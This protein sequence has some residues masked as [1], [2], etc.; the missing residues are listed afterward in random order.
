MLVL[1]LTLV[2]PL[3]HPLLFSAPALF[4]LAPPAIIFLNLEN[5]F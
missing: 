5:I 4:L 1:M 3:S 2:F